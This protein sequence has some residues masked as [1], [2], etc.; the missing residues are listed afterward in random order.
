MINKRSPDIDHKLF[1]ASPDSSLQN[2]WNWQREV[3]WSQGTILSWCLDSFA[4][5]FS[6]SFWNQTLMCCLFSWPKNIL[7]RKIHK[8][9]NKETKLQAK[10]H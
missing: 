10:L 4:V 5:F 3:K 9:S 7:E 2:V 8:V 1:V 6:L